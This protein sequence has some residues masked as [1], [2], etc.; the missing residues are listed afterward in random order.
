MSVTG[1]SSRGLPL[2]PDGNRSRPRGGTIPPEEGR[3]H[4]PSPRSGRG[5]VPAPPRTPS[6]TSLPETPPPRR[7]SPRRTRS[8]SRHPWPSRAVP[9][10]SPPLAYPAREIAG[11]RAVGN[12]PAHPDARLPGCGGHRV[13]EPAAVAV[14]R[15]EKDQVVPSFPRQMGQDRARL[16][17]RSEPERVEERLLRGRLLPQ[18][19]DRGRLRIE[20]GAPRMPSLPRG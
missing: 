12:R 2:P 10:C 18:V 11:F 14:I 8:R 5:C 15:V 19:E 17:L 3:R 7:R 9:R 4:T 16:L 1:R 13:R 6:G 20:D